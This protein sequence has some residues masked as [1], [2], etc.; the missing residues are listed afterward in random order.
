MR[1][2]GVDVDPPSCDVV[3]P[4][5]DL[6][7]RDRRGEGWALQSLLPLVGQLQATLARIAEHCEKRLAKFERPAKTP[8]QCVLTA[9]VEGREA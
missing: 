5:I 8:R 1:S 3:P 4:E 6:S 9:A 7:K 2:M